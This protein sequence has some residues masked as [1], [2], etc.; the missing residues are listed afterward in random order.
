MWAVRAVVP[1][2]YSRREPGAQG[3][4]RVTTSGQSGVLWRS[5]DH[6]LVWPAILSVT[7]VMATVILPDFWIEYRYPGSDASR[8]DLVSFDR[9]FAVLGFGLAISQV[10]VICF[11]VK[12]KMYRKLISWAVAMV[13]VMTAIFQFKNII[14]V[15]QVA[16][17]YAFPEHFSSCAKS[18]TRY[19]EDRAFKICSFSVHGNSVLTVVYDSVGEVDRPRSKQSRE[20]AD[21]LIKV[22][23]P[24]LSEC[25]VYSRS[26]SNGFYLVRSD[27]G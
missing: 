2:P 11:S 10:L 19:F 3:G 23:G 5:K 22:V 20:F 1:V 26:M 21:F 17:V 8:L 12:R 13:I 18:A 25:E 16:K 27:C 24:L 7:V 14:E 9:T 4:Q 6:F 15:V